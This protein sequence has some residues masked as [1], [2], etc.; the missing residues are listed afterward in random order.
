MAIPAENDIANAL[1]AQLKGGFEKIG[2][3]LEVT[4]LPM[5]ELLHYY[6]R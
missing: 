4:E 1:V 3:G 5:H 6:Y 2:L